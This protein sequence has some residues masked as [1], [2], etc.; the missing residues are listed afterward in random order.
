[1]DFCHGLVLLTCTANFYT[2][3]LSPKFLYSI[4]EYDTFTI[5]NLNSEKNGLHSSGFTGR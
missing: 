3:C 2:E 1:M 5:I 4:Y